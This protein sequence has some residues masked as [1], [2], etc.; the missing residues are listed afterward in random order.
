M[1]LHLPERTVS[2]EYAK[3]TETATNASV[4]MSPAASE[5]TKENGNKVTKNVTATYTEGNITKTIDYNTVTVCSP[6]CS[7]L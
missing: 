2:L 3:I 1:L 4:N 5:Y 7:G 6:N